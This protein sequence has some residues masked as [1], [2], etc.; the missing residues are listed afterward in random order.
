MSILG[1][2]WISWLEQPDPAAVPYY[3]FGVA[4]YSISVVLEMIALPILVTSQ[5]LLFVKLKVQPKVYIII[6]STIKF[7]LHYL[8]F[9][10]KLQKCFILNV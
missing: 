3:G 2:V 5:A 6:M 8:F 9:Y 1:Y 7:A 4:A 10:K